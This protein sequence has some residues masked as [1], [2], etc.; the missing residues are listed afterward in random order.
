MKKKTQTKILKRAIAHFGEEKQLKKAAEEAAELIQAI[1]K[2]EP[3]NEATA[4][5][6]CEEMADMEIMLS[7]LNRIT[8]LRGLVEFH[9]EKKLARLVET[10]NKNDTARIA[11]SMPTIVEVNKIIKNKKPCP[12][13]P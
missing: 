9:K 7:Q 13:K 1:L 4:D 8:G 2:Y 6:L 10:M 3:E 11:A 12:K 5:H